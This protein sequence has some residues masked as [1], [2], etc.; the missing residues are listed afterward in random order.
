[1]ADLRR[2][3]GRV[4]EWDRFSHTAHIWHADDRGDWAEMAFSLPAGTRRELVERAFREYGRRWIDYRVRQGYRPNLRSFE[5]YGP[6][7]DAE[8]PDMQEYV[9]RARWWR[10][11][12]MVTSVGHLE[13]LI[14]AGTGPASYL[15]MAAKAAELPPPPPKPDPAV[16]SAAV[17]ARKE[18]ALLRRKLG[19][20]AFKPEASPLLQEALASDDGGKEEKDG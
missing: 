19:A 20:P 7:P 11:R 17:E 15:A 5:C 14:T 10:D 12:P 6:F 9:V 13:S 2:A 8:N 18:A 1:L 3:P 4:V 16:V